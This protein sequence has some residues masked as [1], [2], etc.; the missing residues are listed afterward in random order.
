MNDCEVCGD[1]S[2]AELCSECSLE[3]GHAC[4]GIHCRECRILREEQDYEWE[5]HS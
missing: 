2:E 3:V 5:R 1:P 4:T